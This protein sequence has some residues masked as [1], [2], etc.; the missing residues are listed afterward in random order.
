MKSINDRIKALRKSECLT[1]KEFAKRLLVSQ[2]YL[3]GLENGNEIPTNRLIKLICLEFGISENWLIDGLGD[4]YDTVYEN[5]KAQLATMSNSALLK[6]LTLLATNSN[7]EYGFFACSLEAIANILT[8]STF[9][10]DSTHTDY[11]ELIQNLFMDIERA[12][13]SAHSDSLSSIEQH[14]IN[15][16]TDINHLFNYIELNKAHK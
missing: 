16:Q 11:L 5:E 8:Q 3:S 4:M 2:S 15:I 6:I 1:Q 7:V 9:F 10:N 14:K 12:V 13:Y